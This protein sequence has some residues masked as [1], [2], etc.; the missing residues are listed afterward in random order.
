MTR[1]QGKLISVVV[2]AALLVPSRAPAYSVLTHEA[3]I[4]TVWDV[5]IKPLLMA[6]YPTTS[7]DALNE[8]RAYAYGGS[9]I[10]DLG[11][12]PFGSKFFSNLLHYVRAGDFVENLIRNASDVNELA[13]ALG[14]L[15]HYASDNTGHP[16][17]TNRAVPMIY[18]KM[19]QEFGNTVTYEDNPKRH[20]LVEFSFDVVHVAAGVYAPEAFHRF[21]GFKVAK[22]VLERAFVETYGLDMGDLFFDRSLAVGTFRYAVG[23]AIPQMTKVAWKKKR[24]EIEQVAPGITQAAFVF[25]LSRREYEKQ[26]GTDYAKPK[27]WARIVGVLYHLIP[28]VGPFRALA[29]QAPTPEAVKLFLES[30]VRTKEKFTRELDGIRAGRLNLANTNLD[31]GVA[32]GRGEYKMADDTYDELLV[33]LTDRKF[34]D[35]SDALRA[36]LRRHFGDNDPRLSVNQD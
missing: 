8:A 10:H 34:S 11:Y 33:K 12:Y 3:T 18:P 35:V 5:A 20:I 4:D 16:V 27:G 6:R 36:E 1:L 22:D 23:K 19:Q 25:N 14:A 26:F 2:V 21:I 15:S 24:K 17:A 9:V 28:K 29:F 13:F 30:F 32:T 7:T 31:V